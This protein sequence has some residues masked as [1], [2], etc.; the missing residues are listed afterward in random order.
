MNLEIVQQKAAQAK[1]IL[2]ELDVD[3]WLVFVR[4]TTASSDPVLPLIYGA[5]LTWQSA[6][7]FTRQGGRVAIVGRFEVETARRVGVFKEVIQYDQ[8]I[9]GPLLDLL[10]RLAPKRIAV[11]YSVDDVYADGLGHGLYKVLSDYLAGSPF[12]ERLESAGPIIR[13]LRGRKTG[14]ELARLRA[15]IATTSEIY[16]KTLEHIR[17]GMK[18]ADIARFM[19]AELEARGLSCSWDREHCPTVNAGPDS[20]IGHVGP[21]DIALQSGHILH[22][23]FGVRQDDYCSDIQRVVYLARPGEA[24]SPEPVRRGFE[25]VCKAIDAAVSAMRPGVTGEEVDAAARGIVTGAGYPEYLYATGHQMGRECH[26]GGGILGPRWERYG[27]TPGW[28]L[29]AGQVYTVEPGL[30]VPGYGYIGIEEDVVVTESGAEFLG[31]PQRELWIKR[32]E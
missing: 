6:L 16:A 26:D 9:R 7:I 13:R 10:N 29:E 28:P 12:A 15:A 4:E 22:L 19:H 30:M 5:D 23:D 11:N 25:T 1:G 8:S 2:A 18:E 24:E 27:E 14:S 21:T 32:A 17:P 3:L 20:P 31:A